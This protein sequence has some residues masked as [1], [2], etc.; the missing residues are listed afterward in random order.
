MDHH[1]Q[2]NAVVR[3]YPRVS[4]GECGLPAG[5]LLFVLSFYFGI[6]L[7]FSG[8]KGLIIFSLSFT[9]WL[10]C[11]SSENKI[12]QSDSKADDK[13]KQSKYEKLNKF[14]NSRALSIVK[15]LNTVIV[16]YFRIFFI[17][18]S[19]SLTG[20]LNF[21]EQTLMISLITCVDIMGL[22]LNNFKA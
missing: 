14:F 22:F 16:L 15:L 2:S 6:V 13:I 11:K 1:R 5:I 17:I 10:F 18:F 12:S 8:K 20:K 9:I 7:A 19:I 3:P 4:L 21:F